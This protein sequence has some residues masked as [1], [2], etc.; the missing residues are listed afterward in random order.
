[1][2]KQ[3]PLSLLTVGLLIFGAFLVSCSSGGHDDSPVAPS[4]PSAPTLKPAPPSDLVNVLNSKLA[5]QDHANNEDGFRVY[6]NG[7]LQM[8]LAPN[9]VEFTPATCTGGFKVTA[10]NTGG[11]S[12]ATNTVICHTGS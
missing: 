4:A 1:M 9:V 3:H 10:Y 5:F 8:T 6:R 2:K 12:S 7:G 11:E